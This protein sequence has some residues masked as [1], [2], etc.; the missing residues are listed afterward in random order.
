MQRLLSSFKRSTFSA[1]GGAIALIL[2]ALAVL[3]GVLLLGE[4]Q[5][6]ERLLNDK[7]AELELAHTR[8]QQGLQHTLADGEANI[9]RYAALVSVIDPQDGP[10]AAGPSP[11]AR[12]EWIARFD[13]EVGRDADGAWRSRRARFD[14]A[15]S[16]GV[17]IPPTGRVD[18]EM[19]FFYAR[20][21]EVT[22]YFGC[23]AHGSAFGNTWLLTAA[24]GEVEFDPAMPEFIYEAGTDFPYAE[25]PWMT[26]VDPTSNPTGKPQWTPATFDPIAASWM[27]SVVAPFSHRGVW[28]GSVGHDLGIEALLNQHQQ[29]LPVAAQELLVFDRNGLLIVST[30][31]RQELLA[32]A[33]KLAIKHLT[34]VRSLAALTAATA[35]VANDHPIFDEAGDLVMTAHL[36][37]PGWTTV[38]MVPRTL[39]TATVTEQFRYLRYALLL[40]ISVVGVLAFLLFHADVK[41]RSAAQLDSQVAATAAVAARRVAED[42]NRLKDRFLANMS[43]ELR[44]PMT[45]IIGM[46][47]LLADSELT[48]EQREQL[49][50]IRVSG[51]SLVGIITGLLALAEL[52]AGHVVL[53]RLPVDLGQLLDEVIR[54]CSAAAAAKSIGLTRTI[55]SDVRTQRLADPQ[56]LAQVLCNLV[57]N[58]VQF[59]DHGGVDIA[60]VEQSGGVRLLVSDSGVGIAA[61]QLPRLFDQLQPARDASGRTTSG[62]GLGLAISKRLVHLMGGTIEVSSVVGSGTVVTIDLPLPVT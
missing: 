41:R 24:Q 44:T 27:I 15:N 33:G 59:T 25:S 56:R 1:R 23:G 14:S 34:D 43:H 52:E 54:R 55:A 2:G 11:A 61:D 60:V 13:R 37:G 48:T 9:Q 4:R 39:L 32:A 19:R 17:W 7:V 21:A 53:V 18:D 47:D 35:T 57:A 29:A 16:A 22:A 5:L 50:A 26:V 8:W 10:S 58:A 45:G 38:T 3:T 42:A 46:S 49:A 51:D 12:A 40:A 20:C 6:L 36:S 31:H 62:L 28:G 30:L